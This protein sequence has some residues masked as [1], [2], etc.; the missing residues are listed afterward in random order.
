MTLWNLFTAFTRAN[1]LGYGGGPSVIPLIKAEVVDTYRWLSADEFGDA[2]AI[3]NTLPGPIATK[4]S[5]YIG[6]KVAGPMGALVGLVGTVLPT[7]LLMV[8][9]A[10]VLIQFKDSAV[11]KGM[12]K[13]VKPVIFTLFVLLSIEFLPFARP[14]KA[15]LLP[16]VIAVAS[17]VAIYFFQVHQA[18]VILAAVLIGGLFIQ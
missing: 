1:L 11:V 18:L 13:G 12:I 8:M 15:G 14:D 4:M 17:F 10:A 3:G 16:A 7:A 9:L 6:Y 2:L 5:A